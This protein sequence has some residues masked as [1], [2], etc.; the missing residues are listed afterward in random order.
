MVD[1]TTDQ[2]RSIATAAEE[3]SSASEEINRNIA[4]INQISMETATNHAGIRRR[5]SAISETGPGSQGIDQDNEMRRDLQLDPRQ[6]LS[7]Q[8]EQAAILLK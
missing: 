1:S 2:V 3:Q 7:G 8:F 4:E 5:C 6:A